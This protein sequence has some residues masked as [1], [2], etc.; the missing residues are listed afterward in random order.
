MFDSKEVIRALKEDDNWSI[1]HIVSNFKG[2]TSLISFA[3]FSF[4]PRTLNGQTHKLGKIHFSINKE[5]VWERAACKLGV[6][7]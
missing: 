7:G 3:D 6:W 2:L 1:R 5:I 4:I